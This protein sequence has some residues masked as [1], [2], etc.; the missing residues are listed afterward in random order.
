M[1]QLFLFLKLKHVEDLLV[2]IQSFSPPW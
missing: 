2:L 1:I